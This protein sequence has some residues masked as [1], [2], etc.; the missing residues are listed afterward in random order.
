MSK[1]RMSQVDGWFAR[2]QHFQPRLLCVR[3]WC[4]VRARARARKRCAFEVRAAGAGCEL[5]KKLVQF[6]DGVGKKSR[7]S[8]VSDSIVPLFSFRGTD[9]ISPWLWEC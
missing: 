9:E 4:W 1:K 8:I 2:A 3:A 6:R 5:R 7:Q